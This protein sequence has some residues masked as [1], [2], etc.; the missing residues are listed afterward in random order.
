MT[1][2][3]PQQMNGKPVT[4]QQSEF[5]YDMK[6]APLGGKV[7]VLNPGNVATF[8]ILTNVNR[9]DFKAWAPLPKIRKDKK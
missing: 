4:A 7:I 1:E 6:A 9:K 5:N 3:Q 2:K 8:A